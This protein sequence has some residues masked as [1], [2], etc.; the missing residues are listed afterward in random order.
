VD[1]L[2]D[3]V[4]INQILSSSNSKPKRKRKVAEISPRSTTAID[5]FDISD[6]EDASSASIKT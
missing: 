5:V 1:E 2:S 4:K 3:Q 6:D